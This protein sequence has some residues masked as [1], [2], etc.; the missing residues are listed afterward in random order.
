MC[1]ALTTAPGYLYLRSNAG[2]GGAGGGAP[3]GMGP[4]GGAAAGGFMQQQRQQQP[5]QD[6]SSGFQR[7]NPGASEGST[8]F[9]GKAYKLNRD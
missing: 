7:H 2:V 4:R 6:G 3:G 8:A 9:K 5:G 1:A